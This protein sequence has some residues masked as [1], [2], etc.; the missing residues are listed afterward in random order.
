MD[1]K[2]VNLVNANKFFTEHLN[3]KLLKPIKIVEKDS[4]PLMKAIGWFL[5]ALRI[6]TRFMS[7]Y[8]TTIGNTIYFPKELMSTINPKRFM[9][10]IIHESVHALDEQE[11]KLIYKPSYLPELFLGLPLLILSIILFALKY[12]IIGIV[13]IL[14]ALVCI[15]PTP[16]FGRY[17]WEMR[18]YAVSLL[19]AR[20]ADHDEWFITQ[21]KSWIKGQLKTS[22]YYFTMPIESFYKDED[23]DKYISQIPIKEE[24]KSFLKNDFINL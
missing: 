6:N 12:W 18:A 3:K 24:I 5:G 16:K 19:I 7:S 22:H 15:L 4:D 10:T 2:E 14:L 8:I 1:Y 23:F 13:A 9:E 20:D 21:L 11:N 17:H